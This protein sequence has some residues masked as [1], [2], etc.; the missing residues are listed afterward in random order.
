MVIDLKGGACQPEYA[1]KMNFYLSGVDVRLRGEHD[2]PAIGLILCREKN[3]VIV[4]YDGS[5]HRSMV[6]VIEQDIVVVG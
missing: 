3:R 6:K 2:Q 4:E 5:E 1:G